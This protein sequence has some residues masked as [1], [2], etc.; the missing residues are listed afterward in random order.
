MRADGIA[1]YVTGWSRAEPSRVA[2]P[3]RLCGLH[4]IN[5]RETGG[6]IMERT[7]ALMAHGQSCWMD[8]LTRQMLTGGELRQHIAEHRLRGI[9]ANPSIFEKARARV[10]TYNAD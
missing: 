10:A 6:L 2:L 8:D 5:T 1:H 7:V 3:R 4:A 9:T